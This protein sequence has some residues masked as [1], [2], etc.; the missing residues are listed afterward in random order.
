MHELMLER[1]NIENMIV[2]SKL[3]SPPFA[4][5]GLDSST[6]GTIRSLD[7]N[8]TNNTFTNN[9]FRDKR[10]ELTK[11]LKKRLNYIHQQSSQNQHLLS[12]VTSHSMKNSGVLATPKRGTAAGPLSSSPTGTMA[13]RT[14]YASNGAGIIMSPK[15]NGYNKTSLARN[16]IN[17]Q[18]SIDQI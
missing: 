15:N 17:Q 8:N 5:S 9:V 18:N 6:T 7:H 13:R 1:R 14:Q 10:D 3:W 16:A 4:D 2:N 12:N 11:I